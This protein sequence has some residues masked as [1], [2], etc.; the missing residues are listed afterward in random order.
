MSLIARDSVTYVYHVVRPQFHLTTLEYD[1]VRISTGRSWIAILSMSVHIMQL[2][3]GYGYPFT[4][5]F[6]NSTI[7]I[8]GFRAMT[9][10]LRSV[11]ST[12]GQRTLPHERQKKLRMP[13]PIMSNYK[14]GDFQFGQSGCRKSSTCSHGARTSPA[15]L[16]T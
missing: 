16:F 7:T 2:V 5:I 6:W 15:S 10:D 8:E 3:D 13:S 4:F 1:P 12:D 11:V 14:F 9:G